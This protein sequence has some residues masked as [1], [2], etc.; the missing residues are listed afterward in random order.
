MARAPRRHAPAVV[1]LTLA[2]SAGAATACSPEP[3]VPTYRGEP[4]DVADLHLHTGTWEK[5]GPSVRATLKESLPFP[6]NLDPSG[7]VDES[8]SSEGILEQMDLAGVSRAV[9]FAVYAPETVGV[10]DNELVAERVSADPER[11]AGFASLPLD[12][13]ADDAEARLSKLR[14]DISAY[15]FRGIK[16]AHPHAGAALNDPSHDPIYALA[17]ELGVPVYLHIGNTPAEGAREDDDATHPNS[18]QG[19][20]E[21]H[22][23]TVF[24]L[25]H[26][27]YDFI[28]KELGHVDEA[29]DLAARYPNTLL[30]LSALGSERSDPTGEALP[31]VLR[32]VADHG[33]KERLIYGSDGPQSPGFVRKYLE[34][35]LA[36]LD[37]A[38]YSYDEVAWFLSG[39]AGELLGL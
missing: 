19:A 35:T 29:L 15:G 31:E 5:T 20:V 21:R 10:T 30:E 16:L 36:A 38:D 18:A 4:V 32:R 14:D 1:A 2:W 7:L 33:L 23:D 25:G 8:L 26:V 39:N 3:L 11:L 24:I 28:N 13:F 6:L 22:P 12:G 37:T 27:G 34:R 9:L 17:A